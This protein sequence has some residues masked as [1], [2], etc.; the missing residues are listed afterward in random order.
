[1]SLMEVGSS[2]M[3][4]VP[5]LFL[6]ALSLVAAEDNSSLSKDVS[7]SDLSLRILVK[8][9]YNNETIE[10]E[11]LNVS[12]KDDNAV[13][14]ETKSQRFNVTSLQVSQPDLH[15][16]VDKFAVLPGIL[17]GIFDKPS[18]N[19][20]KRINVKQ[21]VKW[22]KLPKLNLGIP[23]GLRKPTLCN[24]EVHLHP[25]NNKMFLIQSNNYPGPFPPGYMC[26]WI[27]KSPV[28]TR[29]SVTCDT[30]SVPKVRQ[31]ILPVKK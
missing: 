23:L 27:I 14:S 10:K 24:H 4:K 7:S 13:K 2:T 17:P 28:N 15:V 16:S 31:S 20:R 26:R 12:E 18:T 19:A 22:P 9:L 1:M 25:D 8:E 11:K 21:I 3:V 6:I 5:L 29:I 30:F